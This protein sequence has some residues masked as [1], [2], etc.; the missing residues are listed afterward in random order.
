MRA[1]LAPSICARALAVSV[2]AVFAAALAACGASASGA[3]TA[4]ARPGSAS[5]SASAASALA[6]PA[7]GAGAPQTVAEVDGAAAERIYADELSGPS[8]RADERQ[9]EHFAPLLRALARRDRS[10]VRAAVISLVFSHTHIVRLRVSRGGSLLSDVGGRYVIAPV[11]GTLSYHGRQVGEYLLSVQDDLGYFGLETRLIGDPLNLRLDSTRVPIQG[12]IPSSPAILA[13]QQRL[14]VYRGS[15]YEVFAFDAKAFPTGLLRVTL[16]VP[17]LSARSRRSC[18]AIK[19]AES[20]RIARRIWQRFVIDSGSV[21]SYV[22][23]AHSH[24]GA[25]CFVR[26]GGRLLASSTLPPPARLP[27]SGALVYRGAT[28][29]VSSFPIRTSRGGARVYLLV[30]L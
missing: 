29:G 26:S 25:L 10:A 20:G 23:F 27:D 14:V 11:G 1:S 19:V 15:S 16:L 9:V 4:P 24:T 2:A 21:P 3:R 13:G 5:P 6:G 17:A 22:T 7:C 12:T 18:A 8:T 30:A 28:Y